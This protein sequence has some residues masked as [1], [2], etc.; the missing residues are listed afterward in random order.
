MQRF[1]Y[2]ERPEALLPEFYTRCPGTGTALWQYA[3]PIHPQQPSTLTL[4][5]QMP[6]S[7]SI[8]SR[9]GAVADTLK[10]A[11]FLPEANQVLMVRPDHFA[12]EYVINPHME[13]HMGTVDQKLAFL[14]WKAVADTFS[15][16]GCQ[17]HVMPA[18]PGLPDMVFT[19]NQTLPVYDESG[20]HKVLMSIMASEQRAGEVPF[21]ADWFARNCYTPVWPQADQSVRFEGMGDALWHAGKRVLWGGWGYRTTP[22]IYAFLAHRFNIPVIL[23]ELVHP[24]FYHLD[25]CFCVLDSRTVLL[26]PGAFSSASLECIHAGFERVLEAP[27]EEALGLF[28]CNAACPD[29]RNVLVQKGCGQVN[30]LLRANGFHIHELDTGEYLKSGG[31]VFCMK[32]MFWPAR[33]HHAART[34]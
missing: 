15:R 34:L 8:L 32:L 14:Q 23:L 28:A 5:L 18:Q 11:A 21:F 2:F 22:E 6:A 12:V 31:S 10:N 16:I 19:A 9:P 7:D 17:V 33:K 27:E 20:N 4:A 25:T 1:S 13:H 24:D 26:Y 30:E 3:V 29:G